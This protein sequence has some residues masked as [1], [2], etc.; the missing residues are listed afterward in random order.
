MNQEGL[1]PLVPSQYSF[2]NDSEKGTKKS[3][4]IP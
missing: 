4:G 3:L 2:E 1:T